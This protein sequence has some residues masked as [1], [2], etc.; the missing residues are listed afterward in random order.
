NNANGVHGG[1]SES[2]LVDW[3][4]ENT[5]TYNKKFNSR[6]QF[7]ALLGVTIQG[8]HL[9]RYGYTSIR[10]PNEELGIR[11]LDSGYPK[12]PVSTAS[13]NR[14]FSYLA[15]VNYNYRGKYLLTANFRTDGSSKFAPQNRWGYFPSFA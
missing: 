6:H 2:T 15:R 7:D 3:L 12:D 5:I 14:L 10:I 1:F 9:D 8:Q 13:A 11:A 4:N